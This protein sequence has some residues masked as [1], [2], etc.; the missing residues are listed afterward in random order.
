M[1]SRTSGQQVGSTLP[2]K[3]LDQEP[4]RIFMFN[5]RIKNQLILYSSEYVGSVEIKI[6]DAA[7]QAEDAIES[8]MCNP[9]ISQSRSHGHESSL[10]HLH[11][12][13]SISDLQKIIKEFYSIMEESTLV[14]FEEDLKQVRD[15]LCNGSS[16]PQIIPIVGIGGIGKTTLARNVCDDSYVAY[17]F[18]IRAW[19]TLSP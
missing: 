19:V 5:N 14:G 9:V 3:D 11:S 10:Q 18:H 7:Y 8:R 16:G 17:Y 1:L 15:L 2:S 13:L 12:V 4:G 6:R